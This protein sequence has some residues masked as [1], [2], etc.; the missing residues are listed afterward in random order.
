MFWTVPNIHFTSSINSLSGKQLSLSGFINGLHLL[1][2]PIL[3]FITGI[4]AGSYPA[5]V[6]SS[7]RPIDILKNK[8][9]IGGKT[10][11]TKVL[12]VMQFALSVSLVISAIILGKQANYL[13]NKDLGYEK[14]GLIIRD[15]R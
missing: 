4:I 1:A 6:M 14:E 10:Q 2:I 15:L 13:I 11:L 3:A 5:F 8:L 9:R 7:F 12:I